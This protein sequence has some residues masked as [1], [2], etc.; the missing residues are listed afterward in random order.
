MCQVLISQDTKFNVTT[1]YLWGNYDETS[2]KNNNNDANEMTSFGKRCVNVC[3]NFFCRWIFE[4]IGQVSK[5]QQ[6]HCVIWTI[7]RGLCGSW[8]FV[9]PVFFSLATTLSTIFVK[10]TFLCLFCW[11]LY[12][13]VCVYTSVLNVF[14]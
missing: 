5:Q 9:K 2:L 3:V 11:V 13:C 8:N 4:S 6:Q 12:I 10:L 1:K 7:R 14:H